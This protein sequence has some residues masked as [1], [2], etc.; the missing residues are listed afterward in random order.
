[1]ENRVKVVFELDGEAGASSEVMHAVPSSGGLYI[2]DNSPFYAYGISCGDSFR[3]QNRRGQIHFLEVVF[4]G[5]HSTYRV[6]LPIGATHEDFMQ[7]W[8]ELQRLGCSFEGTG[9]NG[10]RLYAVDVPPEADVVAV[11]NYLQKNE[12][13]GFWEFEEAHYSGS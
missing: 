6:K 1:M 8:G 3:A 10:R 9:N 5:G 12:D 2:L 13:S 4:R 7:R 11:Y